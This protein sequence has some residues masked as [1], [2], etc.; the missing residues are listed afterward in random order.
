M[1]RRV[2]SASIVTALLL[3]TPAPT[4]AVELIEGETDPKLN[5]V[6]VSTR[7]AE[8]TDELRSGR[9]LEPISQTSDFEP[10][11]AE[12]LDA[13]SPRPDRL[14]E[15]N[16]GGTQDATTT[17]RSERVADNTTASTR[18]SS[19]FVEDLEAP[20]P[21]RPARFNGVQPGVTT[22]EE[23][24]SEWGD[25]ARH[26]QARGE[27]S[28][29][30]LT[31]EQPPFRLVEALV[32]QEVVQAVRVT[33]AKSGTIAELT[34]KL[35]LA[36][37]E[38]VEVIDP[39]TDE[40]LGVSFPEKGL[41][42]LTGPSPTAASAVIVKLVIEPLSS[43]SFTLRAENRPWAQL[44]N[45][46]ADLERAVELDSDDAHA[47]WLKCL[48]HLD[49]GQADS[50]AEAANRAA[51][52]RPG[53][54]AYRLAKARALAAS[55]DRDQAVLTTRKVLDD[56]TA[57]PLV[58][59]EAFYTLGELAS[60]GNASIAGKS[61]GFHN[62]AIDAADELT[63]S[64]DDRV[65]RA[66]KRL[67]V[68][69]HLAIAIE[70]A[71]REYKDRDELVADWISRA[72]G[73]AEAAIDADDAG[74]ELRL[75]VAS[76]AL[77]ALASMKPTKD[78]APWTEE[79]DAAAQEL[80]AASEDKLF[81]ARVA[82]E[83]GL[84]YQHAVRVEHTRADASQALKYGSLAIDRLSEGAEPRVSSPDAQHTVG[85]LYF[86][87]GAVNAVHRQNHEEAIGW[88]EKA[89]P[90]VTDIAPSEFVAPRRVGEMLVSM[91]VSFWQQDQHDRA[92]ELT[93]RGAELMRQAIDDGVLEE[94]TLAVPYSNLASMH[95][96]LGEPNK[97]SRYTKL[98]RQ[99]RSTDSD[100]AIAVEPTPPT[101]K[102][103]PVATRQQTSRQQAVS[104][105]SQK[106][107]QRFARRPTAR[108]TLG[109]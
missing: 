60:L 96:A 47:W 93:E 14:S 48:A 33:L 61:I 34:K 1:K 28:G 71:R 69:A 43:K 98:A 92:I 2:I 82:W 7:K 108:N 52:L 51:A 5:S 15:D 101:P 88:Y 97:A 27:L 66:A 63:D 85:D 103:S 74:L 95:K 32:D 73:L 91:G 89:L 17:K 86:Y 59:A 8:P 35:K 9:T 68:D 100:A 4:L 72:S 46:L 21:I 104:P 18:G 106:R 65:R 64:S 29:H 24:L 78:P 38:A 37:I 53:S 44:E 109:R 19:R 49:A 26:S 3:G 42:L 50:A 13:A 41:T 107:P 36:A 80:L 90:L 12:P 55:G 6:L 54:A 76:K 10:E 22:L 62:R 56:G 16:P 40:L 83:L 99:A 45:R 20:Q 31:F 84:A 67:L 25:P 23:L 70:I 39:E 94:S 81:Q 75:R 79:A 57:S 58:Q 102:S 87:L 105:S 77:V 30:V 11:L